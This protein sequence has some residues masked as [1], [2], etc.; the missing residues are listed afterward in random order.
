LMPFPEKQ[1]QFIETYGLF[2]DSLAL[3]YYQAGD[4]D[5]ALKQYEKIIALTPGNLF[6]GDIYS[7]SLYMLG[8]IHQELGNAAKAKYHYRDFLDIWKDADTGLPE[9]EDARRRLDGLK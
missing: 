9:V 5:N 8:K 7:K 2:M 6:Y 1:F 3:A 4:L